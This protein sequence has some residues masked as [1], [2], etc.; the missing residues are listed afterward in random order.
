MVMYNNYV[1]DF[2]NRCSELL[3][4]FHFETRRM[5][6]EVTHLL[7]VAAIGL[8]MPYER[9][10]R[11]KE[12]SQTPHP[13]RDDL[14]YEEAVSEYNDLLDE[15]F[16]SSPLWPD[17]AST[18]RKGKIRVFDEKVP[19]F[20]RAFEEAEPMRP[21]VKVKTVIGAIM[22][23]ALAHGNIATRRAGLDIHDLMFLSVDKERSAFR[24]FRFVA[25]E[26]EDLRKFMMN[27]FKFLRHLDL[28]PERLVGKAPEAV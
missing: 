24:T 15:F 4:E 28:G 13:S 18:W 17:G 5:G 27:Y 23:N 20:A 16:L 25:V 19:D 22:R 7:S 26:P 6:L 9:L 1:S 8:I 2:P 10:R 3:E 12:E 21:D 11:I 14:S